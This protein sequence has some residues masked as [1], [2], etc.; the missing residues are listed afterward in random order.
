MATINNVTKINTV[1]EFILSATE[2]KKYNTQVF[3]DIP[4]DVLKEIMKGDALD[5]V[6]GDDN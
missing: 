3:W 5:K 2:A 1:E 4:L 6:Y